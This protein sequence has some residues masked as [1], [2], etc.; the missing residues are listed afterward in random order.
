MAKRTRRRRRSWSRLLLLVVFVAAALYAGYFCL[1]RP[2]EVPAE[3]TQPDEAEEVSAEDAAQDAEALAQAHLERKPYFYTI[4]VSGVDDHNGGSDTNILV[5]VDAE[6]DYIYGVS[7]PRDTKAVIN[8]KNH[9]I[10]FA[11]NSGGTALL[12]ETISQQLGIPVDF[13]VTVD[14]DGF[15]ALVDAIGGVDFEVPISMNYDDPY[16]DL[17]IHFSAGMQHLSGAEALKVVRF[18]E[19]Y[20]TQ[21][22]GRM[23]T[24]QNFLKAVAKQV[25]QI[26]NIPK[27]DNFVKNFLKAVAQQTLTLANV[28]KVGEFAKIFQQYVDTDLSLGNLAWL[29]KEAISM[30]VENISFSTLP[31][32]WR[33]PY[34]YLDPDATLELVNQY[35]NPYV[36]DRTMEDLD[37]P[38]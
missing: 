31:N 10:N 37:I 22:I 25:L 7:I 13:T 27:I 29:G 4:L 18:R 19:G 38:S 12:A 21:D 9:K 6:N 3:T 28:D 24:Q 36:E 30:G 2:P 17:H 35:L 15:A 16:Q 11:Y 1:F 23:Q 5:A 34:I 8:G 20:A 33:S 26:S 14:L 32:E